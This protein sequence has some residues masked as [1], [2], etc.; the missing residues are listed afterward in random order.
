MGNI[1]IQPLHLISTC[2]QKSEYYTR[3]HE[4]VYET[5]SRCP[6]TSACSST[7]CQSIHFNSSIPDLSDAANKAVGYSFCDDGVACQGLG[8]GWCFAPSCRFYRYYV[9]P[10]SAIIYEITSCSVWDTSLR[11]KIHIETYSDISSNQTDNWMETIDLGSINDYENKNKGMKIGL[12]SRSIPA[13]PVLNEKFI[14]NGTHYALFRGSP[15]GR[16]IAGQQGQLQCS[17]KQKAQDM[18]CYF[19]LESCTCKTVNNEKKCDCHSISEGHTFYNHELALPI[20]MTGIKLIGNNSIQAHITDISSV[21]IQMTLK[22]FHIT[23]TT[24]HNDCFISQNYTSIQGCCNCYTGSQL[25]IRCSTAKSHARA[26]IR[27]PSFNTL[28]TCDST[29]T[30]KNYTVHFNSQLVSELCELRCPSN[31]INITITGYLE[32]VETNNAHIITNNQVFSN[33]TLSNNFQFPF[34]LQ[35][36][37]NPLLLF[38]KLFGFIFDYLSAPFMIIMILIICYIVFTC[39]NFVSPFVPIPMRLFS[40]TH[41]KIY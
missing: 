21:Q 16:P 36:L 15:S 19:P 27:C 7:S 2:R 41:A 40:S 39:L 13:I 5:V 34:S 31:S 4:I 24:N 3:D 10:T 25:S 30:T 23:T 35:D 32:F 22:N 17:S 37:P 6:W 33:K 20:T 38:P 11:L 8:C 14:H 18:Q 26:E 29:N 9:K 28:I 12:V 1:I